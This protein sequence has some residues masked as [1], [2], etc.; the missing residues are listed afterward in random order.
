[1]AIKLDT[2][3]IKQ[4]K[5]QLYTANR[6]SHFVIIVAISKQE[7]TSV[8]MVTDWNNYLNMKTTNSDK[9]DFHVIRDILPITDNLVYW[10]VAQQNL[11]TAQTQGQQSEK[12]VDDLEFY[13]NK[14]M[15]E[16]KVRSAE[17]SGNN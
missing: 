6:S 13:T 1:M 7:N 4:L 10:A 3:Q 8:K 5:E 2:E 9:F 17:A 15:S 11:H 14:V 12:V 16:N